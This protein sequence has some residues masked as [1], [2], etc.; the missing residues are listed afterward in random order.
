MI[1]KAAKW[2]TNLKCQHVNICSV[3]LRI[4]TDGSLSK[5]EGRAGAG[6]HSKLFCYYISVGSKRT[7]FDR[8]IKAIAMA[9]QQ[10]LLRPTA[11]KN[12]VLLVDSKSAIQTA[13]SKKQ[14][15]TQIVKEARRTIKKTLSFD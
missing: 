9:L 6:I 3:T 10:L 15:T 4:Y 14:A 2:E 11:F 12:A 1:K 5:T 13:A 8:E 7:S